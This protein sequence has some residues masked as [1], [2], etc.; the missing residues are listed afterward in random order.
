MKLYIAINEDD[1]YET[2]VNVFDTPEKAIEFAKNLGKKRAYCEEDYEESTPNWC[3]FR[4]VYSV[5]KGDVW[6]VEK[7]LNDGAVED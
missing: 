1:H 2:E 5:E 6:V 4:V 3:L 7:E